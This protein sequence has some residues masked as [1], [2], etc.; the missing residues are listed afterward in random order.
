MLIFRPGFFSLMLGWDGLGLRSFLLV[1]YYK[2]YKSLNAGMLTFITNRLG[3]GLML[4]GIAF[5]MLVTG[6]NIFSAE[7]TKPLRI[8]L[9]LLIFGALTKRAQ[10]PFR[11]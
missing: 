10:I 9:Y 7:P 8:I 1:I 5:S 11:A 2:N 6:F 3:D 4:T